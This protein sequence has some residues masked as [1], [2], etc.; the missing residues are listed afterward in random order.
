MVSS[1]KAFTFSYDAK[2]AW[3]LLILLWGIEIFLV[4]AYGSTFFLRKWFSAEWTG[5]FNLNEEGTI[6]AWFSSLQLAIIGL[7]PILSIKQLSKPF[8][9]PPFLLI[10]FGVLFL[11]LS[12]DEFAAIHE[13][14]THY[15]VHKDV[16]ILR[17]MSFKNDHGSWIF[18]YIVIGLLLSAISFPF[19]KKIWTY[20]RKEASIILLGMAILVFGAVGV[21]VIGYQTTPTGFFLVIEIITEEF[22]EMSGASIIMYGL[23]LLVLQLQLAERKLA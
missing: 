12:V 13:S 6:P 2:N 9:L 14:I 19:L 17:A 22:L 23:L 8:I 15:A 11:F 21:E 7:I 1:G 16:K 18:V 20:F 3:H 10:G 4:V 5:F